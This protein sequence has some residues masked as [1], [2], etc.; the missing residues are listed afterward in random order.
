M[1][2]PSW[3]SSHSVSFWRGS[4]V[5]HGVILSK[6]LVVAD[7]NLVEKAM[8][9]CKEKSKVVEKTHATIVAAT[10]EG[11]P[12][13]IDLFKV[14]DCHSVAWLIKTNC[15]FSQAAYDDTCSRYVYV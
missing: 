6:S 7:K 15:F 13:N 1:T 4:S 11:I 14:F 5:K 12:S 9:A 3:A 2:S 10:V 8:V